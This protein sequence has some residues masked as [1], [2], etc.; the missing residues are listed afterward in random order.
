MAEALAV[1]VTLAEQIVGDRHPAN[2]K[3]GLDLGLDVSGRRVA[4]L[5]LDLSLCRAKLAKA[6]T[7][8][9]ERER[10][11]QH[12]RAEAQ[13]WREQHDEV[14]AEYCAFVKEVARRCAPGEKVNG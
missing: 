13:W 3:E 4:Q 14:H 7:G 2:W 11:M 9:E 12:W 8:A 6:L 5:A 1:D 10:L